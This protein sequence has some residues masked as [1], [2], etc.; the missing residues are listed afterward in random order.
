MDMIWI[1]RTKMKSENWLK[2]DQ[3]AKIQGITREELLNKI[4]DT[5]LKYI[6]VKVEIKHE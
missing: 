1:N 3:I 6:N 5:Y 2:L 4:V